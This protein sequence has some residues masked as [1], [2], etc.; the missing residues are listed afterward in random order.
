VGVSR[1]DFGEV[2]LPFA[3]RTQAGR[4]LAGR[5]ERFAE[6][7]RRAIVLGLPRGGVPVAFEV[8]HALRLPMDVYL[9]RKLGTPGFEELAMGAIATG[10]IRVL[11]RRVIEELQVSESQLESV[12]SAETAELLRRERVYRKDRPCPQLEGR[13]AILVDDGLA[14][15]STM[16][17]AIASLRAQRAKEVIVAVPVAPPDTC[18]ELGAESDGAVCLA[19]PQPFLA[20]GQWYEEFSP[21]SDEEIQELLLAN[22]REMAQLEG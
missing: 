20:V 18:A 21:P 22:A 10:G 2:R 4:L 5:L 8:A 17:A 13:T 6:K 3:D 15:G 1:P 16:R 14:T 7:D 19:T 12:L 9:V 11:N